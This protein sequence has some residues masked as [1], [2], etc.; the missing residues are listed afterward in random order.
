MPIQTLAAFL[1]TIVYFKTASDDALQ[2]I[3]NILHTLAEKGAIAYD[4]QQVHILDEALLR[5]I[6]TL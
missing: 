5:H 6:S 4:R 2:T 1:K 3:S